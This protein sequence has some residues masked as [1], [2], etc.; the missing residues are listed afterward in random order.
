MEITTCVPRRGCVVDCIFCPQRTLQQVYE[1]DR[2]FSLDSFKRII[3]K[4]PKQIRITFAGFTE[5]WLNKNATEMLL[6]AHERGHPISVFTTAVGMSVDDVK[7]IKDVPFAPNPN[8]GF[9]LH[10]PDEEGL[11]KHPISKKYIEVIEYIK[12]VEDDIMNFSIMSMGPVHS[13]VRHVYESAATHEMWSRAGNLFREAILRPELLNIKNQFKS[14]YHG[15][16][17]MT[18]NCDERLYHNVLLPNGDVSLCCMDYG[19]KHIL[20]NLKEKEYEEI[21]P[22]PFS[23]FDLCRYCENGIDPNDPKIKMSSE[24][25]RIQK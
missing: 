5:P 8:G 20:G 11:A 23:C 19:L 10:L 4:I 13:E 3:E 18:C 2:Y 14:I 17:N 1:G 25:I 9:T 12:S 6:W 7:R 16:K 21:L 24:L 15:E 22:D